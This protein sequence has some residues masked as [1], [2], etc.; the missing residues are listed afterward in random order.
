MKRKRELRLR[1]KLLPVPALLFLA[2]LYFEFLHGDGSAL[3]GVLFMLVLFLC[4]WYFLGP[5]LDAPSSAG[6]RRGRLVDPELLPAIDA[7]AAMQ[8]AWLRFLTR[9]LY[10][11]RD[12]RDRILAVVL[13]GMTVG[14]GIY[15]FFDRQ[16]IPRRAIFLIA[17]CAAGLLALLI[18]RLRLR[19]E[20]KDRAAY[21]TPQVNMNYDHDAAAEARVRALQQRLDRLEEWKKSGMIGADEYEELRKKYL[22]TKNLP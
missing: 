13:A 18:G 17:L 4:F 20:K 8:D 12:Y 14:T 15:A 7:N 3:R 2:L 19:R 1:K 10:E 5:D 6:V 22:G 16:V 9:R 11:D 21:P